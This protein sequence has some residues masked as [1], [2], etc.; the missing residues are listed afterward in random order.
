MPMITPP[1]PPTHLQWTRLIYK[2]IHGKWN[3]AVVYV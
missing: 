3:Y 2:R 1:V